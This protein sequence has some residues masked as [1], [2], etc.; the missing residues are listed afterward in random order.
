MA[1]VEPALLT[2]RFQHQAEDQRLYQR[3]A[4]MSLPASWI[5]AG[6]AAPSI[7]LGLATGLD[8]LGW[9]LF[10]SVVG[11][12]TLWARYR[13]PLTP[14]DYTLRVLPSD[15][16][17]EQDSILTRTP[18]RAAQTLEER[19]R[20]LWIKHG[21]F[22]VALIPTRGQSQQQLDRFRELFRQL[23]QPT[24]DPPPGDQDITGA[25]QAMAPSLRFTLDS[26]DW[27]AAMS[28][29]SKLYP[30]RP[31]AK[32]QSWSARLW[33]WAVLLTLI[34][35]TL[36]W[37]PQ[38]FLLLALYFP[39]LLILNLLNLRGIRRRMT[40]E[41][42]AALREMNVVSDAGGLHFFSNLGDTVV[43]WPGIRF[44]LEGEKFLL[45]VRKDMLVHPIP[46]RAFE[47]AAQADTF[48]DICKGWLQVT[49][50]GSPPTS[51][52]PAEETGNP[53]QAPGA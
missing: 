39:A 11:S 3:L 12:L 50:E 21:C 8:L 9:A 31:E 37:R 35:M 44:V 47:T 15:L 2:L 42:A 40:A 14:R 30:R 7:V 49:Q 4:S 29:I 53:Y 24:E 22:M 19:R 26:N 5:V 43:R 32:Q 36:F 10:A 17:I 48:L 13:T 51:R 20:H 33:L 27:N 1:T 18:W 28:E 41:C 16:E 6:A 34:P 25:D 46:R 45:F 52:G 38:V 23:S